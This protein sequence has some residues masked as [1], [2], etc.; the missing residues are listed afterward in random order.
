MKTA[1]RIC[2]L[3]LF[4]L[5]MSMYQARGQTT[6]ET[7]N[8]EVANKET[9]ASMPYT[10]AAATAAY[11]MPVN[12]HQLKRY[13]GGGGDFLYTNDYVV[14]YKSTS[15]T[16]AYASD[17]AIGIDLSTTFKEPLTKD[18]GNMYIVKIPPNRLQEFVTLANQWR[19]HPR[20]QG[21]SSPV[22]Q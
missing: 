8:T 14:C 10:N 7:K 21:N 1:T 12:E 9:V 18:T 13:I 17:P 2:T 3:L 16:Y 20:I 22:T 6:I 19:D 11:L 5:G 15:G 4:M